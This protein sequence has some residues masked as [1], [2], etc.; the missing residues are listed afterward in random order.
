M[1]DLMHWTG[2]KPSYRNSSPAGNLLCAA[3]AAPITWCA[4]PWPLITA[5]PAAFAAEIV[6][7]HL[8]AA[9]D[10]P[11]LANRTDYVVVKRPRNPAGREQSMLAGDGP[12]GQPDRDAV[13]PGSSADPSTNARAAGA[14][15]ATPA[16]RGPAAAAPF[17][18]AM[19]VRLPVHL[20]DRPSGRGD[21]PPPCRR[22]R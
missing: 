21:A 13:R 12:A 2:S 1:G 18:D 14:I 6:Q 20:P 9:A 4:Q 5:Q 15:L 8:R 19:S 22:S 10:W 7:A 3:G 16:G 17:V 11:A